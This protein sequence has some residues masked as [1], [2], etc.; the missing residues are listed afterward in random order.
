MAGEVSAGGYDRIGNSC[1]GQLS[2]KSFSMEK[3]GLI[4]LPSHAKK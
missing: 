2:Q 1:R 3:Y 4:K